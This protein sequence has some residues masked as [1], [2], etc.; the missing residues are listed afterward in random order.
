MH[1]IILRDVGTHAVSEQDEREIGIELLNMQ[2][3]CMCVV[4]HRLPSVI[5]GKVTKLVG[6]TAVP[7]MIVTEY[8]ATSGGRGRR[9]PGVSIGVFAQTVQYLDDMRSGSGW[10]PNLQLNVV[11]VISAQYAALMISHSYSRVWASS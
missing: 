11:P 3:D 7:T 1:R 10:A 4:D 9:K 2:T 8:D 5:V 6:V